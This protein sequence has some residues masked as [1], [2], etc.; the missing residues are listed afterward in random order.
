MTARVYSL[1]ARRDGQPCYLGRA[2]DQVEESNAIEAHVLEIRRAIREGR[3]P[4]I[5]IRRTDGE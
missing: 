3:I 5:G 1:P 2:G 4:V